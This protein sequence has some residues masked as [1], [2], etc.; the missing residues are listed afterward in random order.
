MPLFYDRRTGEFITVGTQEEAQKYRDAN[1]AELEK[2]LL[3][4]EVDA[5]AYNPAEKEQ[6]DASL[7]V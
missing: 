1:A 3:Q 5:R 4:A 7:P 2:K 6:S